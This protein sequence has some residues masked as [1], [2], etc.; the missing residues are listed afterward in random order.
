M[1]GLPDFHQNNTRFAK[2][3]LSKGVRGVFLDFQKDIRL[4]LNFT[5]NA[6]IT[7]MSFCNK[8]IA[9]KGYVWQSID[10]YLLNS[11]ARERLLNCF[12][13]S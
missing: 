11:N 10:F 13:A 2:I 6:E 8:L 1:E 4:I 3:A 7:A 5:Q 9:P 12:S